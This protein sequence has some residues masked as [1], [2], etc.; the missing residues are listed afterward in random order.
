MQLLAVPMASSGGGGITLLLPLILIVGMI[1]F[2]SRSQRKQ[3]ERQ[4]QTVAALTPGTKVI[5]TSGLVGIVEET[6]DEYVTLEISEGVLVQVV[7]AAIGRVLPEEDATADEAESAEVTETAEATTADETA[8]AGK[9]ADDD[10]AK[11]DVPDAGKAGDKAD[12]KVQD[13]PKLPPTHTEN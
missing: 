7:K 5:T 9:T 13:T 6:D 11:V 1:W 10:A 8:D 2:M 4:A 12:G 3:R